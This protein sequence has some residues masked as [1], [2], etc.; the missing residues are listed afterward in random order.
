MQ[1][2]IAS[3]LTLFDPLKE[4]WLWPG[5]SEVG[6]F[7]GTH[8]ISGMVPAFFIAGA[9]AI[10]LDKQRV[11]KY[12][13][14][15]ANPLIAYPIAA[16]SGGV[17]TV[18]SCGVLPIFASILQQGAGIGPAFTFLMSSPAINLISLS[19]TYSLFGQL[20]AETGMPGLGTKF[21]LWRTLLVFFSA[22]AIG[23]LM[24]L[25]FGNSPKK[26]TPQL[27]V[28]EEDSDRTDS[29]L[30]VFFLLLVLVMTSATGIF[31][32]IF[33]RIFGFAE[34]D[35]ILSTRLWVIGFEVLLV[36][37][38][39]HK[40]F[41]RE[42]IV[43]WLQKSKDLFIL[44]FPKVLGG[45]FLA[46]T[47]ATFFP[48]TEYMGFFDENNVSGNLISSVIGSIMYFGTI[49][50]I[51]IVATLSAFGMHA[52]PAMTLLLSAPAVSLPSICA[53]VPI[54]GIKKSAV[55]LIL[56]ILFSAIS[57]FIFGLT[58]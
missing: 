13:G 36:A 11:T 47:L 33:R 15:K 28:V 43:L 30:A 24:K 7:V 6:K 26:E 37:I 42:E 57:G 20:G 8:L 31:D 44:I 10:F 2:I 48:L 3:I 55:F 21:M 32:P 4:T 56:V 19:Y 49:I 27:L 16:L 17:L 29:Q 23:V 41:M 9:I 25:V 14:A 58:F 52:G 22:L 50:G 18:C 39:S 40:W 5:L 12:M 34:G 45:I 53:L 54:A 38:A 51:T 35:N 1:N 46:G